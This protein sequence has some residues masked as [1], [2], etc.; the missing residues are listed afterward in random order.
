M[1]RVKKK[2]KKKV[3]FGKD[4]EDEEDV[5]G[6]I[7]QPSASEVPVHTRRIEYSEPLGQQIDDDKEDDDTDTDDDEDDALYTHL[8][9][10][11]SGRGMM[12]DPP[13][14]R[15]YMMNTLAQHPEVLST[16]N[17]TYSGTSCKS[18]L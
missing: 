14:I 9:G 16:Y 13:G 3:R 12:Y 1:S 2:A 11:L 18:D 4:D 17:P 10:K 7:R 8:G 15:N 6:A 5:G